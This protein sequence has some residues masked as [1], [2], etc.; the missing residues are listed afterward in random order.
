MVDQRI[1]YFIYHVKL[2]DSVGSSRRK[3]IYPRQIS[4]KLTTNKK[5]SRAKQYTGMKVSKSHKW[6][7]DKGEW[8]EKK[9]TPDKWEFCYSVTKR[10]SRSC[11]GRLRCSSWNRI[12]LVYPCRPDREE[13][14][15]QQLFNFDDRSQI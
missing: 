9:V 8:K 5:L 1:K 12:S 2:C 14:R 7:Y 11:S 3:I 4:L 10:P 13:T 6:Y 15:R